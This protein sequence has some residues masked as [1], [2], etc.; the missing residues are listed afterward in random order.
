M[1]VLDDLLAQTREAKAT[2]ETEL[3]E[4]RARAGV[5]QQKLSLLDDVEDRVA[6]LV[7][8]T[9]KP[10]P[11]PPRAKRAAKSSTPAKPRKK[12]T[13][14]RGERVPPAGERIVAVL[15]HRDQATAK[16]LADAL[17]DVTAAGVA[18]AAKK[19]IGNRQLETVGTARR[20]T[21]TVY[22]LPAGDRDSSPAYQRPRPTV[23]AERAVWDLDDQ[24]QGEQL[25]QLEL[26]RLQRELRVVR[27]PVSRPLVGVQEPENSALR[28]REVEDLFVDVRRVDG[29]LDGR[30]RARCL[31]DRRDV[32]LRRRIGSRRVLGLGRR[33]AAA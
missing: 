14:P 19:L 22:R 13:T 27:Q 16:E 8:G 15:T 9:P 25:A 20:G 30:G 4:V 3:E 26:G 10:V 6:A 11:A 1:T 28:R 24:A 31:A 7:D 29:L 17:G 18:Q 21:E 23:R 12:T 5:L 2:Y 33:G 32:V